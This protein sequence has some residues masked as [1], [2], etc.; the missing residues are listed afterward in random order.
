[1]AYVPDEDEIRE[2]LRAIRAK[3]GSPER[4]A[5]ID[6][7]KR[8]EVRAERRK[9]AA[10]SGRKTSDNSSSMYGHPWPEWFQMRDTAMELIAEAARNRDYIRYGDLWKGIERRLGKDLG[11]RWL[12]MPNL[13]GYVSD[14]FHNEIGALPTAVVVSQGQPKP[15]QGFF[16]LAAWEGYLPDADAP[17]EGEDWSGMS[18]RQDAFW[19]DQVAAVFDWAARVASAGL[20]ED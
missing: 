18:P 7:V 10:A 17:T 14:H 19:R 16:R 1:V 20:V 11:D 3:R 4:L 2:R 12:Q 8:E 5:E 13:L 6:A 15:E 9:L